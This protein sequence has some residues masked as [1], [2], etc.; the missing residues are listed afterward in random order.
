MKRNILIVL[1]AI[2]GIVSSHAQQ[3]TPALTV[4]KE[5]RPA[6]V[7]LA[8]GKILNLSLANIFLKNSSLLYKS[9]LETK[10]ANMNT[11]LRV[12]F[13]D[14]SYL[15]IDTLLAYQ[16]DTVGH[17]VLYCAQMIDMESYRQQIAN[18]REITSLDLN[19]MIGYTTVDLQNEQDIH[20]PI[21]N[22]FI[23][24]ING[25]FVVAHERSLKRLLKKE[26]RRIL[27]SAIAMPGFSRND[28]KSLMNLL[29]MIQ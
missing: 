21:K 13:K 11:V 23:F 5:F 6:K 12:D 25:N 22:V 7:M 10:E 15:R 16:V 18:N 17:D 19:D 20:F 28:E 27:A 8:D 4:Y 14:R 1:L 26:K 2:A 24:R 3:V 29:K 9:G